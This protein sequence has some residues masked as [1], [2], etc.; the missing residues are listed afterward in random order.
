V[1]QR[2][3]KAGVPVTGA[4]L[5]A[6]GTEKLVRVVVARWARAQQVQA[7]KPIESGP[8]ASGVFAR[9]QGGR[10]QLLDPSGR[11]V[12][13]ALPGS[14]LLAATSL[15][16]QSIVWLVTGVDNAGVERA[17]KALDPRELKD[18]FAVA[19]TPAGTVALPVNAGAGG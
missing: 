13:T 18:R 1:K 8:Q 9:F 7:A 12:R 3:S 16:N 14:G 2:L 11:A 17:A 15:P 4:P 5:G 6:P 19:T 10:L